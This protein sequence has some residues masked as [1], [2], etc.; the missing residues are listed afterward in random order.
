MITMD[1]DRVT[2]Q[3]GRWHLCSGYLVEDV[4]VTVVSKQAPAGTAARDLRP[5]WV[6]ITA[7]DMEGSVT[8]DVRQ[9]ANLLVWPPEPASDKSRLAMSRCPV[10]GETVDVEPGTVTCCAREDGTV[11]RE[12][13]LVAATDN[14]DAQEGHA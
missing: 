12:V 4:Y 9:L 7:D 2:D 1:P 10:C 14:N 13:V 3:D 11:V 6:E 5:M 8:L